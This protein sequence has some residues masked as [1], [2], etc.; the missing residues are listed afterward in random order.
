MLWRLNKLIGAWYAVGAPE[1]VAVIIN[2]GFCLFLIIEVA[3]SSYVKRYLGNLDYL[4]KK[5]KINPNI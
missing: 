4:D 3:N 2:Q 1:M 5:I